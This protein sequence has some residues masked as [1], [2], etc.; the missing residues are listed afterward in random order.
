[1]DH[2][3]NIH[4]YEHTYKNIKNLYL[5]LKGGDDNSEE[6]K[7]PD[8]I[9]P[10]RKIRNKKNQ[11]EQN[12]L[13]PQEPSIGQYETLLSD[14]L[15]KKFV[16]ESDFQEIFILIKKMYNHP[17]I[18]SR[19]MILSVY[20]G[21]FPESYLGQKKFKIN[22]NEQLSITTDHYKT[23]SSFFGPKARLFL[24]DP[25]ADDIKQGLIG[26]CY[27]LAALCSVSKYPTFIKNLFIEGTNPNNFGHNYYGIK[28]YVGGIQKIIHIDDY[29]PICHYYGKSTL[30]S[31][32]SIPKGNLWVLLLEKAFAKLYNGYINIDGGFSYIA[33]DALT[34]APSL[35]LFNNNAKKV[36]ANIM[37]QYLEK[38][39]FITCT[40]SSENTNLTHNHEY[41]II[42]IVTYKDKDDKEICIFQLKNP[43]RK[44]RYEGGLSSKI[45]DYFQLNS[46]LK[47]EMNN[48]IY[49]IMKK[50]N[51]CKI[52]TFI[53]KK[54]YHDFKQNIVKNI[55]EKYYKMHFNNIKNDPIIMN[56]LKKIFENSNIKDEDAD[57]LELYDWYINA[58]KELNK[59]EEYR[60]EHIFKG[61]YKYGSDTEGI[62]Y[63]MEKDFYEHIK[64]I[65]VCYFH[66]D[67]VVASSIVNFNANSKTKQFYINIKNTNMYYIYYYIVNPIIMNETNKQQD[68]H[69]RIVL[70]NGYKFVIYW[71]DQINKTQ[72]TKVYESTTRS[73]IY[74]NFKEGLYFIELIKNTSTVDNENVSMRIYGHKNNIF[75]IEAI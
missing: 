48:E 36:T 24:E 74:A 14:I 8:P 56:N 75:P 39:H 22:L 59:A 6:N 5:S 45:N 40:F 62:F 13:E 61:G 31:A 7:E 65:T 60:I 44:N 64:S 9:R 52:N 23:A 66:E 21:Q 32:E 4:T 47:N 10:M 58:T 19:S 29:L 43:H 54:L 27:F 35:T 12:Q 1:M 55:K 68:T 37:K 20:D 46:I 26:D 17:N 67:Y 51:N 25:E 30:M 69:K 41:S 72:R 16:S 70:N 53:D 73:Y 3:S 11:E 28:L 71:V 34:A 42:G 50:I 33:F 57:I 15:K 49:E 18:E 2:L 63:M 38:G